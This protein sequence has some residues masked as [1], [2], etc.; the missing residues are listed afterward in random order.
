M[1]LEFCSEKTRPDLDSVGRALVNFEAIIAL[2]RDEVDAEQRGAPMDEIL[3]IRQKYMGMADDTPCS[4]KLSP[5]QTRVLGAMADGR[6]LSY[7]PHA[8][9]YWI[10]GGRIP[11]PVQRSLAK[12]GLIER[13]SDPGMYAITDTGRKVLKNRRMAA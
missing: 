1:K 4:V 6:C 5:R 10:N 12:K 7:S 3:E 13:V 9:G 8:G 11:T 2:Y